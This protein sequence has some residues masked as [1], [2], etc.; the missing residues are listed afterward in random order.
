[1]IKKVINFLYNKLNKQDYVKDFKKRGIKIGKNCKIQREVIIDYSHY[2]HISI[3]DNV[4]LA[5]RVHILAHDASTKIH[6]N[7]AKIGK[8]DIKDNVFIGAG[9]IILPGVIIGKNS[10]IGAASVVTTDIPENTVASGNPAKVIYGLEEFLLKHK[11]IMTENPV[12]GEE[13]TLR[14]NVTEKMKEE[15]NE[16]MKNRIGYVI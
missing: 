13:Y 15:M 3:G 8:V 16:K 14:A 2:W 4:T 11:K 9:S 1:M 7:Y 6:L 10:I 5:P 12:F